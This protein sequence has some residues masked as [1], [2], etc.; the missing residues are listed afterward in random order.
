M[1][2]IRKTNTSVQFEFDSEEQRRSIKSLVS[3][4]VPGYKHTVPWK[5]GKWDGKKVFMTATD[6]MRLGTF[7]KL[8]PEHSLVFDKN[9]TPITFDDIPLF[10]NTSFERRE[11]QLDAI[12]TILKNKIGLISAVMGAGKCLGK[13]TPIIMADGTTKKVQDI[14]IG[15]TLLGPDGTLRN[16]LST[17]SGK[18]NLY[19]ITPV[20]GDSY[21]TNSVHLLSLKLTSG[22]G[23]AFYL[24]DGTKI[25]KDN[26][27]PIFIESQVFYKSNSAKSALKAWRPD[28]IEFPIKAANLKIPPYILGI[29]LGDGASN[30]PELTSID[31]EIVLEWDTY[32]KT[33]GCKIKNRAVATRTP[34]YFLSRDTSNTNFFT[35]G[36]E[37]YS[38][39]NNK[40]IPLNYK[41][42]SKQDRLELLAGLLD[43]D[44]SLSR[45]G[46]DFIQKR[47]VL[48]DDVVFLARSLGL[49]AYKT[50]CKKQIKSIAFEG[51][52]YRVSI[53]GDCSIIPTRLKRKRAQIRKQIKNVLRTGISVTPAGYGDYY[54]FE[55]DGDKQFLLGDWQVTHNTLMAAGVISYHLS[56]DS[57]NKV[58]FVVYDT[59]ILVQ[60]VKNL[61][62]YGFN[63]SQFG[64]GT[65]DLSGDIV[66]ATIQSLNNIEKPK[67]VLKYVTFVICDE[68]HHAKSKTSK[69]ILTKLPNCNYFIGLTA[70]P[71]TEDTVETAE[72][73]AV[74]GPVIFK[75]G[76]SDGV[77]AGKI[78]PVKAFFLDVEPDLDIK[79]AIFAR[80]NYKLIWDTAIQFNDVRN[81]QIS[82]ILSYCVD[83]L[84]TPNL[85]LVDRTEHGTALCQSFK[86]TANLSATTMFGSDDILLREIKKG[87]L[88]TDTIN[89]LI[90][91]VCR[92]GVDF[93]ISPVVAVNASGRKG[94]V[95]L[96]QFLGR[97]TRPNK[98]FG[99]FRA[100]I[101][102]IDNYHPMLREHSYHRIEACKKFGVEV[103]VCSSIK[104]LIV[105]LVKY[106]KQCKI[107]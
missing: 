6:V 81:N 46:F 47:E 29:W 1:K 75:Y 37:Y 78:A 59:N 54:G 27:E 45:N 80:K 73:Q 36:L 24:S 61:T 71:Y 22:V 98:K 62:A 31:S 96:I 40:H 93:K 88:Q 106:Y 70:T 66:V 90:S 38:L 102:M 25:D 64:N 101:D 67:E 42:A 60:T 52:Y 20:K 77:E 39:R 84:E 26:T 72:L 50:S 17:T 100:Y 63:V 18:D 32:A 2:V 41:T 104:E 33:I 86:K 107:D 57:R 34:T 89:T 28:A 9:H 51:L 16:V 3:Y 95:S 49:A 35:K 7:K 83:L 44:G 8:F 53:S 79:E 87:H 99:T 30:Q 13:D 21:I 43:T 55:I 19:K 11:Y 58:L 85:V 68:A 15:D 74:L 65:K 91:T 5:S 23:H 92:E 4:Y 105:E 69:A 76:F 82:S 94:F 103:V 10:S 14:K 48:A 56:L 97:I 12:N